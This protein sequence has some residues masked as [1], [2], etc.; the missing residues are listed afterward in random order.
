MSRYDDPG[1]PESP[2]PE[3]PDGTRSGP[4]EPVTRPGRNRQSPGRTRPTAVPRRPARRWIGGRYSTSAI[5]L[6]GLATLLAVVLVGASLTVYAKYREVW[7]SINKVDVSADLHFKRPPA[8]PNAINLLLI[9]SDSR[10]GRN[11]S[12]GGRTGIGGARSDTV[13]VVHI[14]PGAHQVVV[15]SIPRDSVVPIL[16]CSPEAGTTGQTAQP[17]AVEQINATFAYGGPGCLW[18]TIEQTT[19]VHLDDFIAMTFAG[20]ER[21]IDALH[22]VEV[23]LPAAVN[24]P[25]SGL[26][27][28][29]GRHRIYGA[30]AVAFWRTREDLGMGDD[31][32]R[33]QRDQFLMAALFQGIKSSG[34]LNSPTK[35]LGVIDALTSNR[36]ITV[37]DQLTPG[38]LLQ[39]GEALHG[40]SGD[41]VQFVT[42]PWGAY[43][44]NPNWVQWQQPN[45][46]HLFS[47]IAH[48]TKLPKTAKTKKGKKSAKG[49]DSQA[50]SVLVQPSQVQ[51]TVLN[52]TT[53]HG[54]AASTATALTSRG[55]KVIGQPTDAATN[56]YTH[57]V[58]EY[59]TAAQ[60]PEAQFLARQ[61]G[62]A[63]DVDL[64][65]DSQLSSASP[66]QL[67][68]G[69]AFTALP[70]VQPAPTSSATIQN[71]AGTYGGITGGVNICNDEA[72]FA[73]PDGE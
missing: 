35:M 46:G 39:I 13:M 64:Q 31:L 8:D 14:A 4:A 57:S 38:R 44:G 56:T 33:I 17:G 23:C 36:N 25:K 45:A 15:I 2:A 11:G 58:I 65:L 27:L 52:G 26:D 62:P 10:V 61:V 43:A 67:I 70:P 47:A 68:L 29:A 6:G 16:G 55:F 59:A 1:E 34:L 21:A 63:G 22:G 40:I 66:L 5:T 24:D 73:G 19:G 28:A 50:A 7:D 12:I 30:Q 3:Q 37:D 69:S 42:V 49:S 54:L 53:T 20:F 60:L 9:G 51:L 72:A 32:Q 18:K 48:D 71:I 41:S